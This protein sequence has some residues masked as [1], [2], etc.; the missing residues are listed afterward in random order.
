MSRPG[1]DVALLDVPGAIISPPTDTGVWYIE[2]L[3][4]RGPTDKVLPVSSM[5]DLVAKYGNRVSWGFVYDALELFFKEGGYRAY[6]ARIVGAG[7]TSGFLN[8]MD[9]G[10]TISL[11]VTAY[12][13]GAWSANYQVEVLTGTGAGQF[14]INIKDLSG[15]ILE[16]SGDLDTQADAVQWSSGSNLVRI[17]LGASASDPAPRVATPLSAGNDQYATVTDADWST[18]LT[19]FTKDLGPGQVSQPGRTT[20]TAHSQIIGHAEA[21]NRVAILDLPNSN[22]IGTLTG[23]VGHSRFAANFAPWVV[24]PGVVANSTRTV[25][26]CG[27]ICGLIARNDPTMGENRP[28]AGTAGLSRYCTGVAYTWNDIDRQTLNSAGVDVVRNIYGSVV[29]YGWRSGTNPTTDKNWI[30]FANS[31][32]FMGLSARLNAIG[33]GFV[34]DEIDGQNGFTVNAFHDALAGELLASWTAGELFGN[35]PGDAFLVD[36]G[37]TVNTLQ[38]IANQE[39]HAICYVAMAPMAE[40]VQIQIVKTPISVS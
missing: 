25:P 30:D 16:S 31:R 33:Q 20:T 28:S 34:F 40:W 6:V 29:N 9:G 12:G 13:A 36:T 14:Q 8:L 19:L 37:P 23:A 18:G 24:M 4:E 17:T 10:S 35:E 32:F 26:P 3:T 22:T 15:N 2:G 5:N 38:T 27:L 11:V 21:N 39:L 7:A 1:V